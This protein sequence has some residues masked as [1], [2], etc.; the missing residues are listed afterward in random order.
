MIEF[1]TKNFEVLFSFEYSNCK[2]ESSKM[3]RRKEAKG[4]RHE[5]VGFVSRIFNSLNYFSIGLSFFC[6]TRKFIE[7]TGN[8]SIHIASLPFWNAASSRLQFLSAN[9]IR[10]VH[11][12]LWTIHIQTP[13]K[14]L[15]VCLDTCRR[16]RNSDSNWFFATLNTLLINLFWNSKNVYFLKFSLIAVSRKLKANW[17]WKKIQTVYCLW[18]LRNDLSCI[19]RKARGFYIQTWVCTRYFDVHNKRTTLAN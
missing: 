8:H 5:E 2:S 4:K 10:D 6:R 9:I 1:L 13:V 11:E 14:V 19:S 17:N 16:F 15:T 18:K 3:K 7:Q 12:N